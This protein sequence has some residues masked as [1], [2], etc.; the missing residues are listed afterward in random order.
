MYTIILDSKNSFAK[1]KQRNQ[2]QILMTNTNKLN[3]HLNILVMD[4]MNGKKRKN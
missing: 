1:P 2:S 3:Q 4:C